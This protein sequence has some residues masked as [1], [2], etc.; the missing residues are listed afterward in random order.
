RWRPSAMAPPSIWSPTTASRS[1]SDG[2]TPN[3]GPPERF[4]SLQASHEL[5]IVAI[6]LRMREV[7]GGQGSAQL[8]E[9]GTV[10][11]ARQL[12][13]CAQPRLAD[14]TDNH[15]VRRAS[16]LVVACGDGDLHLGIDDE[17]ARNRDR[18]VER[19][20][21]SRRDALRR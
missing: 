14:H 15:R 6:E 19:C 20:P 9:F 10:L 2:A 17:L 5:R 12:S 1:R 8:G 21:A 3:A 11:C 13:E 7:T 16:E 18:D 4:S